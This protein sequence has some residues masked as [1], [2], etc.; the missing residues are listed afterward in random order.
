M[1]PLYRESLLQGPSHVSLAIPGVPSN[2]S[3]SV[4]GTQPAL[5]WS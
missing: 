2:I 3:K 1:W 5:H 4:G